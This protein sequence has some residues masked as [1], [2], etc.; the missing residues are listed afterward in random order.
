MT[1]D[2]TDKKKKS[3]SV[4]SVLVSYFDKTSSCLT[5]D[6]IRYTVLLPRCSDTMFYLYICPFL[7]QPRF[8]S[9]INSVYQIFT[10]RD[11][12]FRIIRCWDCIWLVVIFLIPMH[13]LNK[14]T[15]VYVYKCRMS[16]CKINK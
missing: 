12:D 14:K 13:C 8:Y 4:Y 3:I 10:Y 5:T 7:M 15:M 1:S 2:V 9:I 11:K 6:L 16:S